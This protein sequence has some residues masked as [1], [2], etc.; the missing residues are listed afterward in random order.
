M[1]AAATQPAQLDITKIDV[2]T[3][4]VPIIGT[5]PLIVHNWSEKAK[6]QMLDTQQGKKNIKEPR[7][8]QSEYEASFY[9]ADDERYGF[10]SVAF[11]AATV[12]AARLYG[13]SVRMTE[14]RQFLFFKG[15]MYPGCNQA[16]FLL[17][18]EPKMREDMVTV[19]ISGTDLR[20]RAE[21]P[22][23]WTTEL[24]VQYVKS[25]I[26]RES[27]LSII[28]AAGLTVGVGEWRPE[29]NGEYGTFQIDESREI[30]VISSG[31]VSTPVTVKA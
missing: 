31:P 22:E 16:L 14:L 15:E 10:P 23:G 3:L 12:S 5:M 9:R 7:D 21:F 1:P 2:E 27:V 30:T 25:A 20:Y 4:L 28:S 11:K 8:P 13:K 6:R 17:T 19:G 18:G 24:V 26:T 29:K